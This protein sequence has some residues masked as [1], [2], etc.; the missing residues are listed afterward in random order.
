MSYAPNFSF[1]PKFSV[2]AETNAATTGSSAIAPPTGSVPITSAN[3]VGRVSP[4]PPSTNV[5]STTTVPSALG[6]AEYDR[7]KQRVGDAN[8]AALS[9]NNDK[10]RLALTSPGAEGA[11]AEV[12]SIK[13]GSNNATKQNEALL[14]DLYALSQLMLQ[15]PNLTQERKD[16][17]TAIQTTIQQQLR[18][19]VCSKPVP[20]ANK[21]VI[22]CF[23]SASAL[24]I[25]LVIISILFVIAVV[26]AI[27][28]AI[29]RR[30]CPTDN[31]ATFSGRGG[32]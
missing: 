16:V 23:F 20:C 3:N 32:R 10:V 25:A 1:Q 27:M 21:S 18:D 8:F 28:L 13:I 19:Q 2:L 7:L 26:T 22:D 30:K 9:G 4:N 17:Y 11:K 5:P 29:F 15:D 31:V 6:Q 12:Q 24:E 14:Y